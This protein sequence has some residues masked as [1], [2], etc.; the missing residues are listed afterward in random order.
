MKTERTWMRITNCGNI[1][2]HEGRAVRIGN[3]EF[4]IFNLGDRFLAVDNRCPHQGGPL[5]DG[6][7]SGKS[8]VCPLHAW[9][10]DLEDGTV[11]R[12]AD[13]PECVQTFPTR[14]ENGVILLEVSEA[15]EKLTCSESPRVSTSMSKQSRLDQ[16]E[17]SAGL[18]HFQDR[19]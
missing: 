18:F 17:L 5:S 16:E 6:I 1:P 9:K 13:I 12:P 8:V 14:I 11:Q 10:V 4:A 15:S 7:V 19:C 3:R 2:L